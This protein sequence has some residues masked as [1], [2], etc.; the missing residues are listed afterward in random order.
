MNVRSRQRKRQL[1]RKQ[2]KF[3]NKKQKEQREQGST[4]KPKL[5]SL[6][7]W[8]MCNKPQITYVDK[9]IAPQE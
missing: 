2:Q 4:T 7:V 8:Q 3:Q 6:L 5:I 9:Y 1:H